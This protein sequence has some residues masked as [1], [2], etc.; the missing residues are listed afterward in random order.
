MRWMLMLLLLLGVVAAQEDE[1]SEIE[2]E[3]AADPADGPA[4]DPPTKKKRGPSGPIPAR[5]EGAKIQ[6]GSFTSSRKFLT[7]PVPRDWAIEETVVRD[8]RLEFEVRYPGGK[9]AAVLDVRLIQ[10]WSP[11]PAGLLLNYL[12]GEIE[13][14]HDAELRTEPLLHVFGRQKDEWV[15]LTTAPRVRGNQF[16]M[17]LV[18]AV[19]EQK[20]VVPEYFAAVPRVDSGLP[21]YV[22]IPKNYKVKKKGWA[23]WAVH[24]SVGG[25]SRDA[26]KIVNDAEKRFTKFHGKAPKSAGLPTIFL[27]RSHTQGVSLHKP[28]GEAKNSWD[29]DSRGVRFFLRVVGNSPADRAGLACGVSSFLFARRYGTNVP[30]WARLGEFDLGSVLAYEG[31]KPPKIHRGFAAWE[32][33]LHTP[34]LTELAEIPQGKQSEVQRRQGFFYVLFFHYGPS[35]YKKAYKKFLDELSECG[36]PAIAMRKHLE[37]L[38]YGKLQEECDKYRVTKVV[39]IAPK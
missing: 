20:L 18:V 11:P 21:D 22:Q 16:L 27:H 1:D 15:A 8:D 23:Q 7:L 17:T 34:L 4:G 14:K 39:W 37:P 32:E 19:D 33:G 28:L 38:G 9:R 26:M 31:L 2:I 36:D 35:K 6:W 5:A 12:R 24:P 25:D 29:D 3:E 13:R 30:E 10:G